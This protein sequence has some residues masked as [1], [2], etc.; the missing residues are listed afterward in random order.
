MLFSVK[1]IKI[2]HPEEK[3]LSRMLVSIKNSSERLSFF[4]KVKGPQN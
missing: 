4:R 1:V 3:A 2:S